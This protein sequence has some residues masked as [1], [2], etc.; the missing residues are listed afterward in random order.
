MDWAS[1]AEG[2]VLDQILA[3]LVSFALLADRAALLPFRRQLPALAYMAQA[4]TVVRCYVV[5]LPSGAPSRA[6]DRATR[7]GPAF[8]ALA[9]MLRAIIARA[10]RLA[11]VFARAARVTLRPSP[12][13][14]R[15]A[16]PQG[17]HVPASPAPDTS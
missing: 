15:P 3:L 7:L 5:G 2:D 16:R 9:L 11:G 4:E 1:E 13:R 17:H 12:P 10:R 8:R 6:T 14:G